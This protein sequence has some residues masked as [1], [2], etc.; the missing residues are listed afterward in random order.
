VKPENVLVTPDGRVKVADFGLARATAG[1]NLTTDDTT[2]LG[3]AAYVAPEQMRD[4]VSD[5][6]S[7][8]YSAGVMLFELLTGTPP[9]SGD[10]PL[11]VAYRHMNE[12]VPPPSSRASVPP[13]LDEVVASATSRDPAGRP[14]DGRALHAAVTQVRDRLGLHAAVPVPQVDVTQQIA[15]PNASPL[16]SQATTALPPVDA[17]TA[18]RRRRVWP[19]VLAAVVLL[20]AIGGVGGWWL[21]V[22]RYTHA[23]GVI[24]LTKAA[25]LKSLDD[26]GLHARLGKAVYSSSIEAGLVATQDPARGERVHDGA[27]VTLQLS[28]GPSEQAVPDVRGKTVADAKD[29][30]REAS[31]DVGDVRRVYSDAID[32]G[33]VIRTDPNAGTSLHVGREVTLIVS[34]GVQPVP[35]PDVS[36]KSVDE[37][38]KILTE[39]GFTVGSTTQ[40]YSDEVP[41]GRVITTS[42][43]AGVGAT[44]GSPIGLIVS[45]GPHLYPVPDVTGDN[46]DDARATLEAAGFKVNTHAFP[47]GPGEVLRQSPGG[48]SLQ[49]KGTTVTLFVF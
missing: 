44:P 6:R 48:G 35:V 5:A 41:D 7:D 24:G 9:F 38:T 21:A 10:S 27:T 42:P 47:G 15:R 26:S 23:P 28:K 32:K 19:F 18:R 36:N 25:A 29:A 37:A 45:K 33:R 12:D 1:T 46:V 4:G 40:D 39:A 13:E 20:A 34:K 22:G 2:M 49:K 11:S 14:A 16:Q 3:T 8:V 43:A 31:L 30:L 17:A